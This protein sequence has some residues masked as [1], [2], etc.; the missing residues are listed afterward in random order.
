MNLTII[1]FCRGTPPQKKIA[2]YQKV[3]GQLILVCS[4]KVELSST[5]EILVLPWQ[6]ENGKVT[7]LNNAIKQAAGAYILWID[8]NETQTDIPDLQENALYPA[9]ISNTDTTTPAVNWQIRL[10]PNLNF[11]HPFFTGFE[12]PTLNPGLNNLTK[13][14]VNDPL[15][16]IRKGDLFLI[17]DIQLE[18]N[19]GKGL[20]MNDFW[21]GILVSEKGQ[22]SL[23]AQSFKKA[24]K[25]GNL[26][27]WNKLAALNGLANALMESHKL[28]E[29][30]E[31]AKKSLALTNHQR[32]PYL[33]IYQYYNLNGEDAKAYQQLIQYQ[34]AAVNETKAN[35]DVFLTK[36]HTAFLMAE[37]SYHQGWHEQ[38]YH[39]YEQ[40]FACNSGNVSQPILEILFLYSVEL[41][42]RKKARRYFNALFSE[43]LS[44]QF[45][46]TNPSVQ[47]MQALGLI[48]DKK[49]Y[50]FA[51]DVYRQ[52]VSRWPENDSLRNG[53][54]RTLIKNGQVEEAQALL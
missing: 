24:L 3:C 32:A 38:A 50:E 25:E 33:T 43:Y 10:F 47:M 28:E 9:R 6:P 34:K 39:H 7:A 19:S 5:P 11:N 42:H 37:I 29:A 35:W 45:N 20:P 16:I 36:A 53:W 1:C 46:K 23:A 2:A 21:Q 27:Y 41:L 30:R 44:G 54:I 49:W 17:E 52:L 8:E 51:S 4:T 26:T 14:Q 31:T 12:I 13:Q 22:F 15:Q 40:F 48:K 18:I